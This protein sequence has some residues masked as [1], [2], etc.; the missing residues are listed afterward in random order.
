MFNV[1]LLYGQFMFSIKSID[2]GFV[3]KNGA[4]VFINEVFVYKNGSFVYGMFQMPLVQTLGCS[5][6]SVFLL[7]CF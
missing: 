7:P 3:Y 6:I 2:K 1:S 5:A 4:F